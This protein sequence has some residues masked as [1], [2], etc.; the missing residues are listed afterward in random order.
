MLYCIAVTTFFS[1][2]ELIEKVLKSLTKKRSV[3]MFWTE[4][5]KL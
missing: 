2:V 3:D 5:N 4:N 1:D